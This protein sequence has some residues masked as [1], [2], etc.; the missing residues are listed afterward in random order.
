ML[1]HL[2]IATKL[3]LMSLFASLLLVISVVLGYFALQ[4]VSQAAW[5]MGQGK[6]VV[7][8]ILPPPLYLVEAQLIAKNLLDATNHELIPLQNRL[9]A[10]KNDY[11]QRNRY[12]ED[13]HDITAEVKQTLLGEQRKQADLWW[14]EMQDEFL[15]AIE[16][17]NQQAIDLSMNKLDK[18]YLL[19][20]KG[21]DQTVKLSTQFAENTFNHLGLTKDQAITFL[22]TVVIT[23]AL[24]SLSMAY[25]IIR[26][27]RISLN[28]AGKVARAIA[29]GDLSLTI[30][31]SGQ[32]E[33]GQLLMQMA[34]MRNNLHALIS[35]MHQGVSRL[36]QHSEELLGAA[37]NGAMVAGS[38]SEAACNMAATVEQLSVSLDMVDANAGEARRVAI[39]S[40]SHAQDSANVI[41]STVSEMHKISDVVMHV[42]NNIRNLETI[43][44][45]ISNIVNVIH[46]VAD[47]TNLL[48]LNAA[49]EAARAGEYG[50]GFA[51]VADEVRQLAERTSSSSG[52][53][54]QMIGKIREASQAAVTAMESGVKGVEAGVALSQ[55]AGESVKE[56]RVA[57][58]Q[59]T[60]S[61]E[62]ISNA[63]KEQA[64][65][66]RDIA[67]RV[68]SVSQGA[69]SLAATATQTQESAK[70]LAR[71]AENL[72]KLASRFRLA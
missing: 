30:S 43:S 51:V 44:A 5:R 70:E 37:A 69:E 4:N 39:E 64:T 35:E 34:E 50:R 13:N 20:R 24:L 56:I 38:Q 53:I 6:D 47:Q 31:V 46:D 67:S 33:V 62:E 41:E 65:A 16:S 7:A 17:G 36:K 23:G 68:E 29:S 26:Q 45:D 63:L 42:A 32:D 59:V 60:V 19:H 12:W 3:W 40:A 49:I 1:S 18:H 48:A 71:Q 10:L 58:S 55:D 28:E 57:Q 2:S 9:T 72:D 11:D 52:E 14:R 66:T 21:V 27:I 25:I 15:P 54:T 8:D 61:V 22:L